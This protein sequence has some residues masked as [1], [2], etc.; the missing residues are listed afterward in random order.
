MPI[1]PFSDG[2]SRLVNH[3][4]HLV[5]KLHPYY[6]IHA[7]VSFQHVGEELFREEGVLDLTMAAIADRTSGGPRTEPS[8]V[9]E[10]Q[11]ASSPASSGD[12]AT[13]KEISLKAWMVKHG[14]QELS[15]NIPALWRPQNVRI[16]P[17]SD[18]STCR[19]ISALLIPAVAKIQGPT[20]RPQTVELLWAMISSFCSQ[21]RA[22]DFQA[23]QILFFDYLSKDVGHDALVLLFQVMWALDDTDRE[24]E[25]V[26]TITGNALGMAVT[27][28]VPFMEAARFLSPKQIQHAIGML[29]TSDATQGRNLPDEDDTRRKPYKAAAEALRG[30][31]KGR[32]LQDVCVLAVMKGVRGDAR[33]VFEEAELTKPT[34]ELFLVPFRGIHDKLKANSQT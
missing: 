25:A 13:P 26:L 12:M 7:E 34:R 6:P 9:P 3:P 14:F 17:L 29:R 18:F 20:A 15:Q 21:P 27:S 22:M 5:W 33:R 2:S 16:L 23:N 19:F 31:L 4:L 10:P 24:S 1:C 28:G 11:H 32:K 30:L 8:P